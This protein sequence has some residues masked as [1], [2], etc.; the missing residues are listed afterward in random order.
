MVVKILGYQDVDYIRRS[1]G[2]RV[3]GRKLYF[4]YPAFQPGVV[5][6]QVK[7]EYI[8][9]AVPNLYAA[10]QRLDVGMEAEIDYFTAADGKAV[11]SS[12]Q[13]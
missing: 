13:F 3:I 10:A 2:K 5:G 9:S 4:S 1:D 6:E 12:I 8:S 11:V 7:E